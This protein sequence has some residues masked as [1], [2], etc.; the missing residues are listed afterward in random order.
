MDPLLG[1]YTEKLYSSLLSLYEIKESTGLI[2]V[3][4]AL[5]VLIS[6]GLEL[7]LDLRVDGY[8]RRMIDDKLV[9][10][11]FEFLF[12]FVETRERAI[13]FELM[14]LLSLII[15]EGVFNVDC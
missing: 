6:N 11:L 15:Q 7:S 12:L 10:K 13:V 9:E 4:S 8:K 14:H 1:R 5:S 3:I 2:G